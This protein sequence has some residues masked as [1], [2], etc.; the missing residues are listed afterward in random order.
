M[1]GDSHFWA[2]VPAGGAGTRLWPV[3]RASSPKFLHDLTGT[4]RSLLQATWD[5]LTPLTGSQVLVVTGAA[6]R[7]A[8]AAQLPDLPA[9][10]L[11]AEPAPRDS[12]A[13]IGWAAAVLE[14]RDP[15]AVLGSFAADHVIADEDAFRACVTDAVAAAEQGYVVTIGIEPTGPATGF[16]Y[17]ELGEPLGEGPAHAVRQFVEKPDRSR[18]EAYLATGRFR[19][20]AGMFVVRATVLL[21]LLAQW[22]PELAAG[23]RALAADPS[24]LEQ[25]WPG[26]EKIA[27]DH[28]VAEP[29]AAEGRVAVVPGGF[30]WDDVGDFSSLGALL[31]DASGMPGVRVLG[32]ASSVRVVDATGVVVPSGDRDGRVVAVVGLDD[33]VVVDTP[34]ALL[35][36]SR[37]RAQDVKAVVDLLK[38]EG[39]TDLL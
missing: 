2:V 31:P 32:D 30:G 33:V 34:D 18:A 21:D 4:G 14:A 8:V 7:A 27:I 15:S 26:L 36:V 22:H 25:V 11:L 24:R 20:N 13:A 17:I 12:M 19:W 16:G 39:R 23:V 5:R 28:A 6:H 29:A 38:S 37:D 1:T 35:V 9:D 10:Q 3:S